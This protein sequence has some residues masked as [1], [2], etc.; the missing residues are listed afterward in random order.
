MENKRTISVTEGKKERIDIYIKS[1]SGLSRGQAQKLIDAGQVSQNGKTVKNYHT[2]V[3]GGDIVEYTVQLP[4]PFELKPAD[5]EINIIHEDEDIIVINKHAGLVVHPAPGHD[6]DTLVNALLGKHIKSN[7]FKSAPLRPG[8]VHRLDKDTSGVMIVAKSEKMRVMLSS[9]FKKKDVKKTYNCLV[10]GRVETEGR[11]ST[12]IDRD[13][14]DRKKFTAKSLSGK[15]AETIFK[16]LENFF[17][18]A[19]LEVRILTGRTH[20]I[21]VHMNYMKHEVLGDPMYG[22]KNKD[23]Q[24]VEYLGYDRK[25][26]NDL[27]PRQLLHARRLEFV[28]PLSGKKLSFEAELPEDFSKILDML[29][30]KKI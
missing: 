6:A 10:H 14:R 8:V 1:A 17:N 19:F 4:E 12:M 2:K 21:R 7:D 30:K 28:N 26:A 16:P 20:Q 22:D 24:L 25:S 5:I 13:K 11:L 18:S 3:K 27:L 15:D 9:L 29:R 23:N